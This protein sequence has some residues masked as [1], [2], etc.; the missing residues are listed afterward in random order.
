MRPATPHDV[1]LSPNR[2]KAVTLRSLGANLCHARGPR[3]DING[4]PVEESRDRR[5]IIKATYLLSM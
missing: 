1:F 5:L 3:R 2:A 4:I